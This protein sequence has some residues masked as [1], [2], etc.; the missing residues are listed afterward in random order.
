[1]SPTPLSVAKKFK[2]SP[3]TKRKPREQKLTNIVSNV[4]IN[5][6][7]LFALRIIWKSDFLLL[8]FVKDFLKWYVVIPFTT[9]IFASEYKNYELWT[10]RVVKRNWI[11]NYN[12]WLV[13]SSMDRAEHVSWKLFS[14]REQRVSCRFHIPRDYSLW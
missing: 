4:C 12:D 9:S 5:I 2:F 10:C 13:L 7:F 8:T 14:M 3:D 6:T 1:L 11:M